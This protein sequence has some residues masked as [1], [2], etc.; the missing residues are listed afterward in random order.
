[1]SSMGVCAHTFRFFVVARGLNSVDVSPNCYIA[2][3]SSVDGA[4]P[5]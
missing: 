4:M 3:D 1:V 2:G 5:P